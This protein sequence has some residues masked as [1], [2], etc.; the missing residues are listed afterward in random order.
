MVRFSKN[1]SGSDMMKVSYTLSDE[2]FDKFISTSFEPKY[3]AV[4]RVI[5][6][7]LSGLLVLFSIML[8]IA[9]DYVLF[10]FPFVM[11][12]LFFYISFL[13]KIQKR[14]MIKSADIASECYLELND[15]NLIIAGLSRTTNINCSQI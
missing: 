5:L 7:I 8:L 2:F 9:E 11:A 12:I 15:D 3:K 6:T 1:G 4:L 10:V 14:K 13:P